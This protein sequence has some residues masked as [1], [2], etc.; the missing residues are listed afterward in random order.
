M[1]CGSAVSRKVISS[2]FYLVRV[3]WSNV[4]NAKVWLVLV[5]NGLQMCLVSLLNLH[6]ALAIW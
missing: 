1:F 2:K 4:V 3:T 5:D 6:I